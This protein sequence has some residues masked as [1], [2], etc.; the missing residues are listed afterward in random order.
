MGTELQTINDEM[1]MDSFIAALDSGSDSD[2]MKMSGQA[3]E[4]D[5]PKMGLPRLTINYD[6]ETDDGVTLKRGA[7][8]VWN[9][10]APVYA[11]SV[12]IRPL[13]RTYEWSH[14]DQE[15]RKFACKSVQKAKLGGDFPDSLGGNKCGRLSR[16]EEDS[17][18][19]DDPRVLLSK[20]VNCNQVIYGIMDAPDAIYADGNPAPI[21]NMAFVAY[22]KRSGFIPVKNFIDQE[23]TRN[24]KILMQRA[25]IELTT[26]KHKKGS[27]LYWTPKLSLVK[28]VSITEED[29]E[30]LKKFNDTVKG[31]NDTVFAD[32]KTAQ[33][34]MMSAD[35]SDLANRFAG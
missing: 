21:E 3:D 1:N 18:N 24:K 23:L 29:K 7:W 31:H 6:T 10:T 5:G 25:V 30:L 12:H 14:W 2:L 28:E 20:S 19:P 16:D 33:K 11:D 4:G 13:M 32:Y 8:R 26:E 34:N 9:G 22:F 15:E 27:V 17:L 35:D